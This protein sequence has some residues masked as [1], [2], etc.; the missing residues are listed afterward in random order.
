MNGSHQAYAFGPADTLPVDDNRESL[1][2]SV[3]A[4]P[5]LALARALACATISVDARSVAAFEALHAVLESAFPRLRAALHRETVGS[6]GALLYTW[7]GREEGLRPWALLAHQDVVGVPP[8]SLNAWTHPPFDGV[9]AN[10]WVWGRGALDMKSCLM[11]TMQAVEHLLAEGFRPRRTLLLCLGADEEVGG[12]D[13]AAHI[14]ALLRARF[15][16]LALTLDEGGVVLTGGFPG[17]RKPVALLGV[18]QRGELVL[19]LTARSSGSHS[20]IAERAPAALRLIRALDHLVRRGLPGPIDAAPRRMLA[21]LADAA[22]GP[23]RLVYRAMAGVGAAGGLLY[24]SRLANLTQTTLAITQL[25]AGS[26]SNVVPSSASAVI[27]VRLRPGESTATAARRIEADIGERFGVS[28]EVLESI[29]PS[30][31]SRSDGPLFD[32]LAGAIRSFAPDAIVLPCLSPTDSDSKFYADLA[33]AQYHFVPLRL[34]PTD[35]AGIHGPNERI[36]VE[37]YHRLIQAYRAIIR[38]ID[39]TD[40]P[41]PQSAAQ[42][43]A[44]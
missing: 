44:S 34:S 31:R 28:L 24:H 13:G 9:I 18:A 32:A 35:L 37:G 1:R 26:A 30:P 8:D 20:G 19:R 3:A 29:E 36:E 39:A 11:G 17:V 27:D 23:W 15:G 12:K 5:E 38:A 14:A 7:A 4:E 22:S 42:E 21:R 33:E 43:A 40:D 41:A 6:G 2:S 16:R 10:G 25:E